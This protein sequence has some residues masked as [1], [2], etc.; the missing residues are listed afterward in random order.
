[1]KRVA[2]KMLIYCVLVISVLVLTYY[3]NYA[4]VYHHKASALSWLAVGGSTAYIVLHVRQV[5]E[6]QRN[7]CIV[8]AFAFMFFYSLHIIGLLVFILLHRFREKLS[9]AIYGGRSVNEDGGYLERLL[10]IAPEI[11]LLSLGYWLVDTFREYTVWHSYLLRPL[12]LV[13]LGLIVFALGVVRLMAAS[14][15]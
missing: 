7:K 13:L 10:S 2:I 11:I 14:K 5:R 6:V 12:P 3:A 9:I 4:M 15:K 1:M 8:T